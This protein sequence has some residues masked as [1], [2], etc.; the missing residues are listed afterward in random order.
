MK[1]GPYKLYFHAKLYLGY[2]SKDTWEA[3]CRFVRHNRQYYKQYIYILLP[4]MIFF[5]VI[6]VAATLLAENVS[7]CHNTA[8]D[9]N[10]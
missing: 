9:A 5:V 8:S 2:E 7:L 4:F 6:V 10:Y 1:C 3:C